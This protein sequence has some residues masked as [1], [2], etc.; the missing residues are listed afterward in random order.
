MD[1]K[2]FY[3]ELG[4]L[5][6]A[7]AAVDGRIHAKEAAT[8]KRIVSEQLVPQEAATDHFGTDQAYITEFE[9]DIQADRG[10]APEEAF[11]SFATYLTQHKDRLCDEQKEL[12]LRAADVVAHAFHGVNAKELRMLAELKRR[13]H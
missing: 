8:M 1:Q 2:K 10:E 6:Y 3:A 7:I 4:R 9:F 5:L 12:V 13:L 11:D